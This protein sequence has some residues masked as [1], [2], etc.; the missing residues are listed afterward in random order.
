MIGG[1]SHNGAIGL[2]E[3][4]KSLLRDAA[5]LFTLRKRPPHIYGKNGQRT[6]AGWAAMCQARTGLES[7]HDPQGHELESGIECLDAFSA[8]GRKKAEE[9]LPNLPEDIKAIV[10]LQSQ[11]DPTLKTTRLYTRL[12]V[13]EVGRQLIEQKGYTDEELPSIYTVGVICL[14][15]RL[16]LVAIRAVCDTAH[17]FTAHGSSL[18]KS[19]FHRTRL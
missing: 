3:G 16:P 18:C 9:R 11:I 4:F 10:D 14:E 8:R 7:G 5:E 2:S 17:I 12:T 13:K 1:V 19:P 6:G 15:L